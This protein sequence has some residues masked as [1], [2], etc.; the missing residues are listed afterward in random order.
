MI[1]HRERLQ[2]CLRR[3]RVDRTPVS[4]WRHFPQDDQDPDAL[5]RAHIEFQATYDFDMVKI[6]PASSFSVKDWGVED[7]WEGNPEGTR[8]YTRFVISQ[9]SDW[10]KLRVVEPTAFHLSAQIGCLRRIR[11][12]LGPDTPI[13]Q[14]VFGPL[15]QAKHLAGEERLLEHLRAFPEAVQ[16]GLQTI[17]ASAERF[18]HAA[19]RA[20]VDGVFYA[21]QHAQARL[22]TRDEFAV[23]GRAF[24]LRVLRATGDLWCNVL[25]LH[26]RNVYFDDILDYPVQ[27]VN[28][29]DRETAPS[30]E[31]ARPKWVGTLC[32]GLAL[33]TL[34][35]GNANDVV[36]EAQEAISV[37]G[38]TGFILSTG[39]V[40]PMVTPPNQITAARNSV[41]PPTNHSV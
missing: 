37:T 41:D 29:H 27:I 10:E 1:S 24:D 2:A 4:L 40:V 22:L 35:A 15:S 16:Q 11:E 23:F 26:G 34:V 19:A 21:V 36:R 9:P 25:H 7:I 5:A 33:G 13:V 32:G 14:T 8:R 39:C 38:G 30:L 28:W 12:A 17:T 18:I 6:T 31:Q 3:E 20:G